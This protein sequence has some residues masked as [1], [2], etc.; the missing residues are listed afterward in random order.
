LGGAP[1]WAELLEEARRQN[2]PLATTYGMTETASQVVT[3]KPEA[4][5]SGNNSS[6]KVLPHAQVTIRSTTGEIL[7]A[8][9]TGIITI[10][11]DSLALGYYP[12]RFTQQPYFQPD[13]LGFFDEQGYLTVVGRRSN[14]II[15]GG[16]NVFPAEVEA[17]ILATQVVADVC[18]IG[19]PDHYWGQ[20]VTA[21]YI[22]SSL[23]VSTASLQAA[24]ENKL[25]KFK[26]PKY[27]VAVET[28]PRNAQGKVNYDQL[29]KMATDSLAIAKQPSLNQTC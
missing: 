2:I 1:A 23:D 29:K 8:N 4:F 9:Q 14:K 6:G 12:K 18:V 10:Q 11:T 22:P 13:D 17:A 5:L 28:L 7:G 15:T 24:V 21:V 26:Q 25:S 19:L 16:E 20:V 27:W 3:L